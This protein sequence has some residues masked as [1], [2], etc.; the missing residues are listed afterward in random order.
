MNLNSESDWSP[1]GSEWKKDR[2]A[3][4]RESAAAA[5]YYGQPHR[6]SSQ[7]TDTEWRLQWLALEQP[8]KWRY[9]MEANR[10]DSEPAATHYGTAQ[11]INR[12]R[13]KYTCSRRQK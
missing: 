1:S 8:L 10:L 5:F 2:V 7:F 12:V 6:T 13:F 4:E 11:F 3:R 9:R